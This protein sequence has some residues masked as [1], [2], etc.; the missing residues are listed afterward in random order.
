MPKMFVF[1][2]PRLHRTIIFAKNPQLFLSI[3]IAFGIRQNAT[4]I[5]ATR[6]SHHKGQRAPKCDAIKIG[7]QVLFSRVHCPYLR[8]IQPT[9]TA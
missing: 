2:Q 4:Q 9:E 5:R 1:K 7:I 8:H 3:L 6:I